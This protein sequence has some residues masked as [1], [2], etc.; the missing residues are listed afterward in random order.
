M[1]AAE[2]EEGTRRGVVTGAGQDGQ[3]NVEKA[4]LTGRVEV[5]EGDISVLTDISEA[6][7]VSLNLL[8]EIN[9]KLKPVLRKA[10]KARD[11]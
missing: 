11:A 1:K 3:E 10:L 7:V 2:R 4:G 5:K 6:T 8:P 9:E